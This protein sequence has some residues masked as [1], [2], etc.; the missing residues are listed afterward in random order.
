[1][2]ALNSRVI[3]HVKKS[4]LAYKEGIGMH[5]LYLKPKQYDTTRNIILFVCVC[6][7]MVCINTHTNVQLYL[8]RHKLPQSF[9]SPYSHLS[10]YSRISYDHQ[11][12]KKV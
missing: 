1:M 6:K 5:I 10:W 4:I 7:Q 8:R 11:N 2:S 9:L 12:R 3:L